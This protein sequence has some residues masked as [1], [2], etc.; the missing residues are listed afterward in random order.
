MKIHWQHIFS[1]VAVL[2][3]TVYLER[4]AHDGCTVDRW[5]ECRAMEYRP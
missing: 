5:H 3:M 2:A 1:F 4:G